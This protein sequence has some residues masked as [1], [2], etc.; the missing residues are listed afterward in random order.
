L[1]GIAFI[2]S[3]FSLSAQSEAD[4]QIAGKQKKQLI[5][6]A[7]SRIQILKKSGVAFK[8]A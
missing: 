6:G 7:N 2:R 8:D 3:I 5:D 4:Q 1:T